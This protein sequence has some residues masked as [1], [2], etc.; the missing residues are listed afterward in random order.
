VKKSN[1]YFTVI[2]FEDFFVGTLGY[3]SISI[4]GSNVQVGLI[5]KYILE[6]LHLI[7]RI[8]CENLGVQDV[9]SWNGE[10]DCKVISVV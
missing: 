10:V 8:T 4:V 1:N 3:A 5:G 7:I 9:N 6:Q 2:L